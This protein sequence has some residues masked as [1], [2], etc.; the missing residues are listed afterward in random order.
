[1][2]NIRLKPS[3]HLTLLIS[4]VHVIAIGLFLVLPLPILLKV[5]ATLAFC[6]SLAFYLKRY[7]RLAAPNSIIA[8]EAGEDCTCVIETRN[9]RR[10]HGILLPTSYVS[11][12]LTVLNLKAHGE[13]LAR[14]VVILPDAINSEDF[15]KLRV[16]LRWKYKPGP[17]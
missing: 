13:R 14:H 17:I 9:G 12:S 3:G 1:M 16:F 2:L 15:R 6:T 8:L 10:L 7:A 4:A 11:A 5:A